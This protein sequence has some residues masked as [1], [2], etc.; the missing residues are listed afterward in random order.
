MKGGV[1][2]TN[3]KRNAPELPT[4]NRGGVHATGTQPAFARFRLRKDVLDGGRRETAL[5]HAVVLSV[6]GR[7]GAANKGKG[8]IQLR[9][10]F[11]VEGTLLSDA[12]SCRGPVAGAICLQA[13]LS[14]L[15]QDAPQLVARNPGP[16][17]F[18]VA[19]PA[20]K[21]AVCVNAAKTRV[22]HPFVK[23]PHGVVVTKLTIPCG[24]KTGLFLTQV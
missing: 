17:L 2:L 7:C 15:P 3:V 19:G 21:E 12:T 16:V 5:D 13:R 9:G 22:G 18:Y 8:F 11:F 4:F 20:G 6:V 10:C 24:R 14:S 23:V 1:V